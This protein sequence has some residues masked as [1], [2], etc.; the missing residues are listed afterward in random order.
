MSGARGVVRLRVAIA[1]RKVRILAAKIGLRIQCLKL[2][3][4]QKEL[5]RQLKR[6]KEAA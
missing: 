6:A 2:A 5:S 1:R 3:A 4:Q